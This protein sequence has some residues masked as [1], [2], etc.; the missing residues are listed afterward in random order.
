MASP[1]NRCK[2]D[3]GCAVNCPR[4]GAASSVLET[5]HS[6]GTCTTTRKRL[7]FNEHRFATVEI[8]AAVFCSA[9]P[10]NK[11]FVETVRRRVNVFVRDAQIAKALRN[12]TATW[13]ALAEKFYLTKSAVYLAAKRGGKR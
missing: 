8:H 5:R 2:G 7:C 13:Q 3:G 9:K 10:R 4:C 1:R 12:K 11:N 6:E